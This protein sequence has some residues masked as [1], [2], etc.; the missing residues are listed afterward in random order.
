MDTP[1]HANSSRKLSFKELL[2]VINWAFG[3]YYQ[4][5]PVKT[6]L[7]LIT[8]AIADLKPLVYSYIFAQIL[9]RVLDLAAS[10][11]PDLMSLL[12]YTAALLFY[13]IFVDGLVD[14]IYSYCSRSIDILSDSYLDV[15][16]YRHLHNL[17][18]ASLEDP[19]VNNQ[20]QRGQ[21]W[22]HSTYELMMETVYFISRLIRATGAGLIVYSFFP[23]LIPILLVW[24]VLKFLPERFYT[25]LL[26]DWYA[27]N[28]EKRR[29]ANSISNWLRSPNFLLEITL[30]NAY[31]FLS[32]KF[33]NIY[34]WYNKNL[35]KIYK[36]REISFFFINILDSFLTVVGYGIILANLIKRLITVGQAT[37]QMRALDTFSSAVSGLLSSLNK[38]NEFSIKMQDMSRLFSRGPAISDGYVRLSKSAAPPVI[39]FVNVSFKYPRSARYVLRNFNL[40]IKPGEKLAIIGENG[41]GKTTLVKLLCRVYKID[42]GEILIN[43]KNLEELSIADWYRNLGV[44]F[45]EYNCY[46]SLNVT[47]NI[48]LGSPRAKLQ[49]RNL[50]KAS[51]LAEADSFVKQ[52]PKGYKQVLSERFEGGTRPSTGQW[53]KIALARFFYRDSPVIIFDE[54][55]A[56]IDAGSEFRIFNRIYRFFKKKTVIMISHR[57]STVRNASKIIVLDHG[58]VLEEGSHE[59]LMRLQGKYAKAFA[60][61]AQGYQRKKT[62]R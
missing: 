52:Y 36:R 43:G 8:R 1:N 40:K 55:T 44:L 34:A 33:E 48:F 21:Q 54:P 49:P 2:G 26:F 51:K 37:F 27:N 19:E 4:M 46:G 35:L 17:G 53:Q 22:L 10:S 47:E 45:Q 58:K 57:F 13:Y 32:S 24:T 31:N 42:D 59:Q 14:S 20:V 25:H 50:V 3:I 7:L 9:D 5:A 62:N 39:E 60:L 61:Q 28:T 38:M 41:A 16:M 6:I 30:V 15:Y 18:V 12:P 29:L 56:S 23:L 11:S